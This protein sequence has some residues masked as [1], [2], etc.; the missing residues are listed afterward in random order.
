[1]HEVKDDFLETSTSKQANAPDTN[2]NVDP[3]A[4]G[5]LFLQQLLL[6]REVESNLLQLG[7]KPPS[8]VVNLLPSEEHFDSF[9][10]YY[11]SI[12]EQ[13]INESEE[14]YE[15]EINETAVEV[16]SSPTLEELELKQACPLQKTK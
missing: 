15:L 4:P 10:E 9:S 11:D 12:D 6:S 5:L 8:D 1:M 7:W 3:T 16:Y 14:S 2:A 13:S